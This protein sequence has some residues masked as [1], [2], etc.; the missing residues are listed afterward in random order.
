MA[1]ELAGFNPDSWRV[2]V[3]VGPHLYQVADAGIEAVKSLVGSV[4]K[5]EIAT[6]RGLI[7]KVLF[8][9]ISTFETP[10]STPSDSGA[11]LHS[12]LVV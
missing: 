3:C 10:P 7:Y 8:P 12:V 9:S 1:R 5:V 6:P 11:V 4:S 2:A